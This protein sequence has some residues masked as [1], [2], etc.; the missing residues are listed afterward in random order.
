MKR[1][2]ATFLFIAASGCTSEAID[3]RIPGADPGAVSS[4]AAF[5]LARHGLRPCGYTL[6]YDTVDLG[7]GTGHQD[8]IA[9]VTYDAAG[10]DVL[11]EAVDL[12]GAYQY[13]DASDYDA[14]G[15]LVH[16]LAEHVDYPT[17]EFTLVYDAG[18]HLV[19]YAGDEGP[20]GVEDWVA[21]YT[22]DADGVR[23]GAHLVFASTTYDRI[24]RYGDDGR[25]IELAKDV[26]PDG[27]I[28]TRTAYAY[29]DDARIES[30]TLTDANGAVIGT[31][32]TTYDD[33]N[34]VLAVTDSQTQGDFTKTI[35]ETTAYDGD[36]P[37]TDDFGSKDVR[38]SD[39]AI[40]SATN[41]MTWV[42][43]GCP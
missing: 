35:W 19:R 8:L 10:N 42:Y 13:R 24:Y 15:H 11:E 17:Q 40:Q 3:T 39:Q 5:D 32:S 12:A 37:T 21:T 14:A 26:G 41:R 25:L 30:R 31:G 23:T 34:H 27:V 18:G 16:A 36:R 22:Y 38:T 28:D 6:A 43:S 33:R 20:D 2:I 1:A 9:T 29:D 7:G 4:G